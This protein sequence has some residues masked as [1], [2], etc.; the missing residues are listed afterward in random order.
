M[1]KAIVILLLAVVP[2]MGWAHTIVLDDY[3]IAL[4]SAE[5]T[6]CGLDDGRM[7]HFLINFMNALEERNIQRRNEDRIYIT[8]RQENCV[9]SSLNDS[10]TR[11]FRSDIWLTGLY[12]I[13]VGHRSHDAAAAFVESLDEHR[14]E[15]KSLE[16]EIEDMYRTS[17][18]AGTLTSPAQYLF[19]LTQLQSTLEGQTGFT[20]DE[21]I[22]L[23]PR[24]GIYVSHSDFV[25]SDNG[26]REHRCYFS[27]GGLDIGHRSAGEFVS[28]VLSGARRSI[29]CN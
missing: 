21:M 18:H 5:Y 15:I 2:T 8:V 3:D 20:R 12:S 28:Y 11:Y 25:D 17:I 13:T 26:V 19:F 4:I 16:E 27:S 7:E 29:S 24:G 23:I 14:D 1:K 10:L 9:S 22:E 6:R